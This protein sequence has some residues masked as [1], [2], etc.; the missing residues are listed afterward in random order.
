MKP[1]AAEKLVILLALVG[2]VVM[3]F[4]YFIPI[5][6]VVGAVIALSSIIPNLLFTGAPTVA[7]CWAKS[8]PASA[9][10]AGKGSTTENPVQGLCSACF[11]RQSVNRLGRDAPLDDL[12][13]YH[14]Y[15]RQRF[16]YR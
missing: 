7:G 1:K 9:R 11:Y 6:W 12:S 13:T 10:I 16:R 2:V 5:L 14:N 4:G 3:L 15:Q 8:A